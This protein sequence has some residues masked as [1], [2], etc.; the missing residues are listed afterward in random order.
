MLDG[1]KVTGREIEAICPW[2]RNLAPKVAIEFIH[3][4]QEY[5]IKKQFIESMSAVL[6]RRE[7][8]VY[9]RLAEGAAADEQTRQIITKNPP[10]RGLSKLDNWGD[11]KSVV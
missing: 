6:E 10:G 9:R 11:R 3:G 1:H 7:N 5:R 8:G 4:G 2:G